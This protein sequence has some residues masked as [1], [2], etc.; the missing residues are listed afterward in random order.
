MMHIPSNIHLKVFYKFYLVRK[1]AYLLVVV[2]PGKIKNI[3][4]YKKIGLRRETV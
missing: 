2:T 1:C 4:F 3:L